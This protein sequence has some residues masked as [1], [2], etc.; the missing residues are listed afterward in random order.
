[1]K[2][3]DFLKRLSVVCGAA[4]ACPGE[5]LKSVSDR[6]KPGWYDFNPFGS[7]GGRVAY[8]AIIFDE[9]ATKRDIKIPWK[10][11]YTTY[12]YDKTP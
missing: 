2:R 9:F 8:R 3:R 12:H 11:Y 6:I 7:E 10:H 4:V 5:L 1:M